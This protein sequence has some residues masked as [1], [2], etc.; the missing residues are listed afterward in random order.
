VIVATS[1]FSHNVLGGRA[2]RGNMEGRDVA[3]A[4][5]R[6]R[7][8]VSEA[9][10]YE[11]RSDNSKRG[12]RQRGAQRGSERAPLTIGWN[13]LVVTLVLVAHTGCGS[14][15]Q[16]AEKTPS[17]PISSCATFVDAYARC[18]SK[19]G[20]PKAAAERVSVTREALTKQIVGAKNDAERARV[21]EQCESGLQQLRTLCP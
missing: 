2:D 10:W 8:C 20:A 12:A 17:E 14:R 1:S 3:Q 16:E 21:A 13:R 11:A 9:T 5:S 6:P 15:G 18:Q 4:R 7:G 19:L